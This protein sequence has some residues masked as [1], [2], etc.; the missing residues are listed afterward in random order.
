MVLRY[1]GAFDFKYGNAYSLD[2]T[3]SE[4]LMI[5]YS[6]EV[7]YSDER[8]AAAGCDNEAFR[9]AASRLSEENVKRWWDFFEE[10][11]MRI[12][13]V[14]A[15][16]SRDRAEVRESSRQRAGMRMKSICR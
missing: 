12:F 14:S 11:D 15:M 2:E 1:Y 6:E 10:L 16:R 3:V 4:V 5:M 13:S 8:L 9:R 7:D